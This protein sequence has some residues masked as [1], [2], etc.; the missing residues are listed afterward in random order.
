MGE[1]TLFEK[2]ERFLMQPYYSLEYFFA[3]KWLD[4]NFG[5]REYWG[6]DILEMLSNQKN[7]KM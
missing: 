6:S 4:R 2:I 5:E 3:K 1:L 7:E